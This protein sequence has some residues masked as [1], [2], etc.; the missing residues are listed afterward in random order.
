MSSTE[1]LHIIDAKFELLFPK[2]CKII[3]AFRSVGASDVRLHIV[4]WLN[5]KAQTHL[6]LKVVFV[7]QVCS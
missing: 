3:N 6:G 1:C 2:D 7:F 4:D 5:A